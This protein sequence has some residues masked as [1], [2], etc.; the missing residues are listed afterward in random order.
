MR[1]TEEMSGILSKF[2]T[3]AA[4]VIIALRSVNINRIKKYLIV[5]PSYAYACSIQ[6]SV[7]PKW[8]ENNGNNTKPA[9]RVVYLDKT[10]ISFS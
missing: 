10:E 7:I 4:S 6:I 8:G 3:N 5:L 2:Y 1:K 9:V